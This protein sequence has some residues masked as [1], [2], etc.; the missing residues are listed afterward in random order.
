MY[1]NFFRIA[2]P[3]YLNATS[4]SSFDIRIKNTA[5]VNNTAYFGGAIYIEAV[6]GTFIED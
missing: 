1:A 6:N 4:E 3:S 5:F 2:T